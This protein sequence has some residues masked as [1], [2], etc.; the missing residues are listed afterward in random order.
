MGE[1]NNTNN[2]RPFI[3]RVQEAAKKWGDLVKT[4]L[5]HRKD[6]C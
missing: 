4:P 1:I 2:T 3:V 6:I 5:E